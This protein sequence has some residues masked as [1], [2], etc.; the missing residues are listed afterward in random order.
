MARHGKAWQ[1]KLKKGEMKM[2]TNEQLVQIPNNEYETWRFV[3]RGESPL[4]LNRMDPEKLR[5]KVTGHKDKA[6]VKDDSP[7]L[8]A[9]KAAYW[10]EHDDERYVGFPVSGIFKALVMGAKK[11][12][13]RVTKRASAKGDVSASIDIVGVNG[14]FC[15]ILV[16]G[17]LAT[18]KDYQIDERP[19]PSGG[20]MGGGKVLR[21]RPRFD[22]W[23]ITFDCRLDTGT[24][25]IQSLVNVISYAGKY[26]GL[27][28]YRPSS[29]LKSPGFCGKFSIASCEPV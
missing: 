25:P 27:G 16:N 10:Y 29:A 12:N 23:T 4:L 21:Y 17:H 1:G 11:V 24:L 20:A 3:I 8:Q 18:E 5:D 14:Q 13:S 15:S 6:Q 22:S 9:K 2:K 26:E 28:D 19:A 7:E